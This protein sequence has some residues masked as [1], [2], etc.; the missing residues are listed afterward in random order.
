MLNPDLDDL[1]GIFV[2][3][4]HNSMVCA[5]YLAKA[6]Q[7]VLVLEAAPH[8]GGGT[9]TDEVTLPGFRHNLHAYF[10]R[11]TPEYAVWNDLDLGRYGVNSIYPEVQNLSIIHI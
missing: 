8:I 1:D 2:G 10:V 3:G 4:G 9:T 11:W 6:G 5:A 7:R